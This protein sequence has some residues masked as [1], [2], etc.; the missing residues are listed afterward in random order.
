MLI[1]SMAICKLKH[2][3][4]D[5]L[6]LC[7]AML[8]FGVPMHT[9]HD[10][11]LPIRFGHGQWWSLTKYIVGKKIVKWCTRIS[12]VWI[13][14]GS[15]RCYLYILGLN[16]TIFSYFVIVIYLLTFKWKNAEIKLQTSLQ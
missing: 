10:H 13:F 4:I 16:Q 14:L 12:W 5:Y 9:K 3:N 6:S 8:G 2:L 15:I 11:L 1:S 7:V